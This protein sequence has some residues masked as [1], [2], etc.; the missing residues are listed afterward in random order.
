MLK[1]IIS[2][3]KKMIEDP[4]SLECRE[5]PFFISKTEKIKARLQ[6]LSYNEL[7]NIWD[8]NDSIAILNYN[9]LRD[10]NLSR[11]ITPAIL[12]YDGIRFKHMAPNVFDY[13]QL[14]YVQSHLV[15][16]SGFY[17]ALRPFDGVVAYRL[18]MQAKLE[19]ENC[20]NLYD[21]WSDEL[22]KF[23]TQDSEIIVNLASNEYSKTIYK[24][25]SDNKKI[26]TCIFAENIKGKLIEKG[27]KC[28]MARGEMV[29]FMAENCIENPEK[30][31]NFNRLNYKFSP[32]YS[33]EDK[34]VFIQSQV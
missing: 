7:K 17:G 33:S 9:R 25:I 5:M 32:E 3:A 2:P 4:D 31:K 18:E 24:Y 19:I 6:S 26:I 16:L 20:K 21:F 23:V 22:Y 28:K 27:T 1:I 14:E 11:N 34:Y 10:M 8:C 30:I 15:I 12:A 13:E 29:R